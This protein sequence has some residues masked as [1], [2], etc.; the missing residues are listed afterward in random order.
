MTTLNLK[1][2]RWQDKFRVDRLHI[3]KNVVSF[4]YASHN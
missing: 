3:P 2:L 1:S 4:Q